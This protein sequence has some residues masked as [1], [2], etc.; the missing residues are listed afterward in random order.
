MDWRTIL[1]PID[2]S[3][4]SREAMRAAAD[5]SRRENAE[6]VLL[7]IYQLPSVAFPEAGAFTSRD[8]I[9]EIV[10]TVNKG[11]EQWKREAEQAGTA[12]VS[13]QSA[14]GSPYVEIVRYAQRHGID[15]IVMGTHGR[16]AIAR[17]LLGSVAEKVVRHAPCPVLTIRP[18]ASKEAAGFEQPAPG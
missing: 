15:L 10:G 7:H 4:A 5:V 14:L 2:F 12:R 8:L 6:L 18:V 9:D 11:L 1:C 16:T 17:A 13:T 3:D